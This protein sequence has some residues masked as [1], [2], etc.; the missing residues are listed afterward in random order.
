MYKVKIEENQIFQDGIHV[1]SLSGSRSELWVK[2]DT[3]TIA[4]FKYAKPAANAKDFIKYVLARCT[5]QEVIDGCKASSPLGWAKEVFGYENL[6]TR[7]V[8]K[9]EAETKAR[10]EAWKNVVFI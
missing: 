7:I 8:R 6:N 2:L 1:G 5:P 9:L 4:R 10:E 3:E